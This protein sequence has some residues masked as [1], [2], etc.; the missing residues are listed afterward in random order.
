[1]AIGIKVTSAADSERLTTLT[2]VQNELGVDDDGPLLTALIDR[3]SDIIKE[4]TGRTFAQETVE[5]KRG[6]PGERFMYLSRR[7]IVS[8]DSIEHDGDAVTDYE[9]LDH[10]KGLL[11]REDGFTGTRLY[12]TYITD[13]PMGYEDPDWKITYTA[14]YVLPGNKNRDLPH[15]IEFAAMQLVKSFYLQADT[16][17]ALT[18]EQFGAAAMTWDRSS[19]GG[20][21]PIVATIMDKYRET[22]IL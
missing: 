4:Y 6:S 11:Y 1:M 2:S 20:I 15:D 22:T 21:P 18:R 7:P 13:L 16:D 12:K 14:G 8:I 9:I 17:P 19:V 5:E 3:A 10:G